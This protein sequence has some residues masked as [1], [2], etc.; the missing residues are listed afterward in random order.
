MLG[1][2]QYI[3]SSFS[4]HERLLVLYPS[5]VRSKLEY[6]SVVWNLITST[7][8]AKLEKFKENLQRCV[9]PDSLTTQLFLNTE[10]F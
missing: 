2:I 8:S 10:T 9:T 5:R 1:L 3:T 4:T 6:P 7:D